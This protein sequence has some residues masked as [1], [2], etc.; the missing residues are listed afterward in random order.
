MN[1]RRNKRDIFCMIFDT[2]GEVCKCG[3]EKQRRLRR[4]IFNNPFNSWRKKNRNWN[5]ILG[6]ME[7]SHVSIG[8]SPVSGLS[9]ITYLGKQVPLDGVPPTWTLPLRWDAGGR[10]VRGHGGPLPLPQ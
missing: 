4:S 5:R 3:V 1:G 9:N 8:A 2:C 10:P 7:V 6:G